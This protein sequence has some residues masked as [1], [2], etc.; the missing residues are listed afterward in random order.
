MHS[1]FV[2]NFNQNQKTR[3]IRCKG[4]ILAI[5]LNTTETTHVPNSIAE[6]ISR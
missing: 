4:T 3:N 5:E 1:D 2:S 6:N